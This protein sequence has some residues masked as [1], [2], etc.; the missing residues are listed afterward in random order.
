MPVPT[1][2]GVGHPPPCAVRQP[3]HFAAA[4]WRNKELWV[5]IKFE[6]TDILIAKSILDYFGRMQFDR[7]L[8]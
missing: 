7:P 5:F 6:E 1:S 2:L 4:P 3:F 8:F